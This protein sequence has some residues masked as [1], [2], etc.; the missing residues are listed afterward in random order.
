[1]NI[2]ETNTGPHAPV[3]RAA[4]RTVLIVED[5]E[6]NMKLF[7]D[8]LAAHGY[9][10]IQT[11]NGLE[12]LDL[13]RRH[14]PALIL[15]DIQL[16]EISGLE[17]TKWIKEDDVLRDIPV[18]AITAFAMK[19]DEERI[20]SGGCEAYISK[21]ISVGHFLETVQRFVGEPRS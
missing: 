5:N 18:V 1:M 4:R 9:E 14:H 10:T 21:P 7:H 6:L 20:R 12:A 13:A 17:V 8:I 2:Q 3:P 11:R 16:P 15:M 19:G